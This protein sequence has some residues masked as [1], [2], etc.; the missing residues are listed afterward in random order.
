MA[1]NFNLNI[2]KNLS[3]NVK[4]E[5]K[6]II[7]GKKGM[8]FISAKK[9]NQSTLFSSSISEKEFTYFQLTS[10]VKKIFY[11]YKK[12]MFGNISLIYSK[13]ER[14]KVKCTNVSIFPLIIDK[15]TISDFNYNF[16][17]QPEIIYE[18]TIKFYLQSMIYSAFIESKFCE[19]VSRKNAMMEANDNIT[20]TIT[21]LK[22]QYNKKRQ[23]KITNEL[24]KVI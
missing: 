17:Q 13:F 9:L 11:S 20:K 21:E 1:G 5:D 6:I 2:F 12:N 15:N 10:L 8:N 23:E 4:P 24:A 7:F 19:Q 3:Q 22:N 18:K 14:Q 16:E